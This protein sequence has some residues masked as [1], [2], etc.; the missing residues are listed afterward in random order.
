MFG[1]ISLALG[2]LGLLPFVDFGTINKIDNSDVKWSLGPLG[3]T[4][5]AGGATR[6]LREHPETISDNDL[7]AA[8]SDKDRFAA[9]HYLLVMR[10]RIEGRNDLKQ[11]FGLTVTFDEGDDEGDDGFVARYDPAERARLQES[12]RSVKARERKE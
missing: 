1:R 9:A 2:L 4:P 7:I 5:S 6:F 12:W 11:W 8:L 10:S 3:P